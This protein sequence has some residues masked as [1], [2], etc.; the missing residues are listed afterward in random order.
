VA[1]EVLGV[2]DAAAGDARHDATLA[3]LAAVHVEVVAFVGAQLVRLAATRSAPG[4]H[5]RYG[6]DHRLQHRAVVGVGGGD[7]YRQRDSACFGED[8]D[9]GSGFAPIDGVRPG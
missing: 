8:V 5:G 6:F 2:F 3:E 9:L 4:P 1:A 7:A